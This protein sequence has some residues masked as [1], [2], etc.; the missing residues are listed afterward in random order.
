MYIFKNL[1]KNYDRRIMPQS[2]CWRKDVG[3]PKNSVVNLLA[4]FQSKFKDKE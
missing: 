2:D 3:L 4:Q 1:K